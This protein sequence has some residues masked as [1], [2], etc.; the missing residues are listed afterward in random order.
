V[1]RMVSNERL[2]CVVEQWPGVLRMVSNERLVCVVQQWPG[3]HAT[4]K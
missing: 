2:V 3:V 1:L 4:L